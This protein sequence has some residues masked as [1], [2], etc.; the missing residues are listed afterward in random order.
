MTPKIIK[1]YRK[2]NYI[3]LVDDENNVYQEH[4]S[5]V[6]VRYNLTNKDHY[7]ISLIRF[8]TEVKNFYNYD[9]LDIKQENDSTFASK[10]LWEDWYTAN[11]GFNN[12][13]AISTDVNANLRVGGTNV[14]NTNPVP[15]NIVSGGGSILNAVVEL[16]KISD[17]STKSISLNALSISVQ[18]LGNYNVYASVSNS[19]GV[20][21]IGNYDNGADY[22]LG[23]VVSIPEGSPYGTVGQLYIRIS[24]PNN[25]GYPPGTASWQLYTN[26]GEVATI[27]PGVSVTWDAPSG[28]KLPA[29]TFTN[30]SATGT[31]LLTVVR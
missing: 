18:N 19:N 23:D 31:F 9:Y 29:F 17:I 22:G 2:N 20:S 8:G 12:A 1:I 30:A 10:A 24:N 7:D 11:T 21:Y 28:Y 25:P 4:Y 14:S 13:G 6:F 27:D 15:V 16:Y 3:I 5:N 26:T